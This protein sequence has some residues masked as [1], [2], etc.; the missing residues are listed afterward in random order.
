MEDLNA[1]FSGDV[2]HLVTQGPVQ[3]SLNLRKMKL[4]VWFTDNFEYL[5]SLLQ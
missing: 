2:C 4:R 3:K 1:D 5:I